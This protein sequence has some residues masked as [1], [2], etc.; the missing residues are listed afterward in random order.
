MIHRSNPVRF[1]CILALILTVASGEMNAAPSTRAPA[2]SI[3]VHS[4]D[5]DGGADLTYLGQDAAGQPIYATVSY[6]E[7][8]LKYFTVASDG[9]QG[10][11]FSI[12]YFE[13]KGFG[14]KLATETRTSLNMPMGNGSPHADVPRDNFSIRANGLLKVKR[15]GTYT[16][17]T[18]S[19]DGVRL[20]I[21][22]R[23]IIDEWRPMGTTEFQAAINLQA[24]RDYRIQLD[25]FEQG[26]AGHL[27]LLWVR[28]GSDTPSHLT[29]SGTLNATDLLVKEAEGIQGAWQAEYF[30]GREFEQSKLKRSE[31]YIEHDFNKSSPA[32]TVP[33]TN[34]SAR[35]TG[36][37]LI[38]KPGEFTFYTTSDDGVRLYVNG[39]LII[40]EWRGMAPT[41][42]SGSIQLS[43]DADIVIEYFQGGGGASLKLEWEGPD[44]R[45]RL[46]GPAGGFRS[47]E[48]KA[49]PF[50][51][52]LFAVQPE[53]ARATSDGL[54]LAV[55]AGGIESQVLIQ[56][57]DFNGTVSRVLSLQGP[58]DMQIAL[59][60]TG[61]LAYDGQGM[62]FHPIAGIPS[63]LQQKL[64]LDTRP[65]P[66]VA[67]CASGTMIYS[68]EIYVTDTDY[69]AIQKYSVA[70]ISS[71]TESGASVEIKAAQCL[72]NDFLVIAAG[73]LMQLRIQGTSISSVKSSEFSDSWI[74]SDNRRGLQVLSTSPLVLAYGNRV[75]RWSQK[76]E[77]LYEGQG[78][79][80]CVRGPVPVCLDSDAGRILQLKP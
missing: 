43:N 34:F 79:L 39:K 16:F 10:K 77:L 37:L 30:E 54:R 44:S 31:T 33:R 59:A 19:D 21:N 20:Y 24:G 60:S 32:P 69:R 49:L 65:G 51:R 55:M 64:E 13:G 63:V 53:W 41:E 75:F 66:P 74:Q 46:L 12:D 5:A 42:H 28:P 15:S 70:Q 25:Y 36:K 80:S 6:T 68:G 48:L 35:W 61:L 40:D 9:M 22:G 26:G 27:E 78:E 67:L 76:L 62:S 72:Q 73:K 71:A 57:I 47:I 11:G 45:R 50:A 3:V 1:H 18:R 7:G 14:K 52:S 8:Q 29:T 56:D 58:S 17:V 4:L 23:R 2:S 38:K